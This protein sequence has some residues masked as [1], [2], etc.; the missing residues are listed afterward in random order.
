MEKLTILQIKT[1]TT[2][3]QPAAED[4]KHPAIPMT[5]SVTART[6]IPGRINPLRPNF[7]TKTNADEVPISL[8]AKRMAVTVNTFSMC[9]L[10]KKYDTSNHEGHQV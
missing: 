6:A 8:K 2:M 10:L 4:V 5:R 7:S 1:V 9:T 3:T